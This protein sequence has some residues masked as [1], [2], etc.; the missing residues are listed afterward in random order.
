MEIDKEIFDKE[1][2]F[3]SDQMFITKKFLSQNHLK[4]TYQ[5]NLISNLDSKHK[6]WSKHIGY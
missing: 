2:K 6:I 1:P 4:L 5:K 3:Y